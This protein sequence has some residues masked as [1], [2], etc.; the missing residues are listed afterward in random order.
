MKSLNTFFLTFVLFSLTFQSC[1]KDQC[2]DVV[3]YEKYIPIYKTLEEI[4]VF[5]S[6][7]PRTL[8]NPGAI[9]Y[10]K[11]HLLINEQGEGIHV[12]DN[13]D[14]AHPT[15]IAF[16]ELPGNFRMAVQN[17]ILYADNYMDLAIIDVS[18]LAQAKFKSRSKKIFD[19]FPL[20]RDQGYFVGY[21]IE[22]V[23]EE[24]PCNHYRG[25]RGIV[26]FDVNLD[27]ADISG[28]IL[29]NAPTGTNIGSPPTTGI[30]GS[31]A[32][33]T[34]TQNHLYTLET[35]RMKVFDLG[36][37]GFPLIRKDMSLDWGMET[38][39]PYR[40]NLFLGANDGVYIYDNSNPSSPTFISKF[41]HV[42][43]CDPVFVSEDIAFVTLN[44]NGGCA[45]FENQLDVIDIS[46]ITTPRLIKTY[47]MADPKGLSVVE[48][49][50]Y[51]CDGEAGLKT[52][53]V[54]DLRNID[55][56][57]IGLFDDF[58]TQDV[59]ALSRNGLVMVV[60]PDGFFQMDASDPS[61]MKMLSH[62]P[63]ER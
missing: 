1:I 53:D 45:G 13:Q 30:G 60:G 51:L 62:I 43:S 56:N 52:F 27:G 38:I 55:K 19:N 14:P 54:S 24:F 44:G 3:T 23:T 40:E 6:T 50:L 35:N 29:G 22:E 59:I 34:I 48:K 9:Y 61:N 20:F 39:F 4:R 26:D 11:N 10:Y 2:T 32:R 36:G 42:R 63:V 58:E 46:E 7:A 12:F 31:M 28:G 16:W 33:F 17:D 21:E 8:K 49:N 41:E 15:P 5:E 25:G 57:Q 47:P 18:D 37:Q